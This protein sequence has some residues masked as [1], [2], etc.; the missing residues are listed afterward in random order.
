MDNAEYLEFRVPSVSRIKKMAEE[1]ST[2]V[3]SII[4]SISMVIKQKLESASSKELKK[5]IK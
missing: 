2:T 4:E 1:N 5:E 3:S